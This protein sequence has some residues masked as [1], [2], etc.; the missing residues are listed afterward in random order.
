MTGPNGP[1][2]VT[3]EALADGYG[4]NTIVFVP[5]AVSSA[6]PES[7]TEY[8]VV[9]SG[10]S[11]VDVPAA[12]RYKVT[13]IDPY[14]N[15]TTSANYQGLWWN[16]PAGSEAGWASTSRIR[17]MSSSSPGSP[18]IPQ[19]PP[20]WLSMIATRQPDGRY[21]GT[22]NE[23]R[24][25]AFDSDPFN[26][27]LV[28]VAPVGS[29]HSRV[30]R[31]GNSGRFSYNVN[32]V[33]QSKQIERQVFGTLPSCAFGTQ[34][35]LALATNYQ[36]MWWAAPAG[37]ESGWGINF[38]HQGDIIFGTWFTYDRDNAPLWLSITASKTG[39]ATYSGT[40]YR[41]TGP[42]FDA[43][44]FDPAS[45]AATPVG[46]AT[47]RFRERQRRT[48]HVCGERRFPKQA[49]HARGVPRPGTVCQ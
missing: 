44:P 45:V 30:R 22:L 32:G 13:V 21:S 48:V 39:A 19:A 10:I 29:E 2:P 17:A 26:G 42:A 11:G 4:D 20:W 43:V 23:T 27:A 25:P 31:D 49:D 18:T 24:G 3:L 35:N 5:S 28:V 33:S 40:L 36:D 1:I 38:S 47:L 9:I 46:S 41:T 12:I 37:V 6:K 34:A 16:S 8:D 14:A 15:G 7:D